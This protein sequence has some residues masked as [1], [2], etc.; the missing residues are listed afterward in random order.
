M[1]YRA[2]LAFLLLGVALAAFSIL[3]GQLVNQ[4]WLIAAPWSGGFIGIGGAQL[5]RSRR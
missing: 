4:W 2:A 1:T 3:M 5:T